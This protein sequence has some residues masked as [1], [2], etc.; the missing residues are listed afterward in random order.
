M[1]NGLDERTDSFR[2][3]VI[4]R[5][6]ED[7]SSSTYDELEDETKM[8]L[9]D[10]KSDQQLNRSKQRMKHDDTTSQ[11]KISDN[12]KPSSDAKNKMNCMSPKVMIEDL[13]LAYEHLQKKIIVSPK[14]KI[15]STETYRLKKTK[16]H[17]VIKSYF[18]TAK[19]NLFSNGD[20][21]NADENSQEDS[22]GDV[23][24]I[25][26]VSSLD[27]GNSL[28]DKAL[29]GSR[30]SIRKAVMSDGDIKDLNSTLDDINS[31]TESELSETESERH[32]ETYSK[33]LNIEKY[34]GTSMILSK[35]G[36]KMMKPNYN[37]D[38]SSE[39]TSDAE[40]SRTASP[41]TGKI[42]MYYKGSSILYHFCK[43]G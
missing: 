28:K 21:M 10:R 31:S 22:S 8:K 11:T 34:A 15:L 18:S 39:Q 13:N 24:Q 32:S 12:G 33:D 42:Y 6:H 40:I 29:K 37:Y 41:Q 3:S 35:R 43:L 9:S 25:K 38:S 2:D 27:K 19:T 23:V 7:S 26:E 20:G 5:D 17:N 36:R 16:E 4:V 14:N 30:R 1:K